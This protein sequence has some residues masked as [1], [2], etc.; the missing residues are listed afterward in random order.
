MTTYTDESA[1]EQKLQKKQRALLRIKEQEK[2]EA[3]R[4]LYSKPEGRTYLWWL[5][6][7][8]GAIAQNAFHLD[9]YRTAFRCGEQ[10]VGQQILAHMLQVDTNAFTEIMKEKADGRRHNP[11]HDIRANSVGSE[12]SSSGTGP[13]GLDGT[14]PDEYN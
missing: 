10:N 13:G 2:L 14:G 11:E 7:I 1:A 9:P 4:A 6:E 12:H 8:S 3:V 5:L